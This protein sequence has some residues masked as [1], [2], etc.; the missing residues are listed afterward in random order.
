MVR[1][2]YLHAGAHRTGT[3]SFQLCMAA[4]RG[5]LEA[6]GYDLAYPGRDGAPDGRL[7]L[8]LPK[9]SHGDDQFGAFVGKV[10]RAL[11]K[12]VSE[13]GQPLILSEENLLGLIIHFFSGRLYPARRK[14]LRVFRDGLEAVGAEAEHI[15]LIVRPYEE[16]FVSGFRKHA[17]DNAVE[18]FEA[19]AEAMAAFRGGWPEAVKALQNVLKPKNMTVIEYGARGTSSELLARLLGAEAGAYAEPEHDL[20]VSATDAALEHL[21]GI[22]QAGTSLEREDWQA[23]IAEFAEQTEDRGFARFSQAQSEALAARYGEDLARISG[24]EGVTLI[25]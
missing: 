5:Q 22:Y 3:S 24:F 14:R 19:H 1:K 12:H 7:H 4:N 2:L 10:T 11:K 8:R 15:L 20:N 13:D 9:P 6:E 25:T 16:L 23:V 17:E 18:P 21:Q